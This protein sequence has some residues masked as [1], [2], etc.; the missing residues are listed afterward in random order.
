MGQ[1]MSNF[2]IKLTNEWWIDKPVVKFNI[3]YNIKHT[4]Y[5]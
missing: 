5:Y 1:L 4:Y 2:D 3:D